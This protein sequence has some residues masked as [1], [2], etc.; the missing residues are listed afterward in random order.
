MEN[1]I[2]N[3]SDLVVSS[4][5]VE[6]RDRAGKGALP[7]MLELAD[8]LFDGDG[9]GRNVQVMDRL[10]WALLNHPQGPDCHH[11]LCRIMMINVKCFELQWQSGIHDDA[12]YSEAV[13]RMMAQIVQLQTKADTD[14][15]DLP[16]LQTCINWLAAEQRQRDE[17]PELV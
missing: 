17:T 2:D 5:L 3:F 12:T 14:S 1:P 9:A 6:L 15:W 10:S 11:T 8:R 4:E 16:L 7:A 13:R